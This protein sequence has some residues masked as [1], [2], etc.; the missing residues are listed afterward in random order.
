MWADLA[1]LPGQVLQQIAQVQRLA[2]EQ[3]LKHH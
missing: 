2:L 3:Q 1:T